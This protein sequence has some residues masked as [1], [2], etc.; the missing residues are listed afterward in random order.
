[1][2]VT[3]ILAGVVGAEHVVTDR[4]VLASYETDWTGRFSGR[5]LAVVRPR[6]TT[7]VAG[8]VRHC[9]DA[10]L[11]ICVQGGNT[12]L[13]GGS[14]PVDGAVLLSLA[15]LDV[16]E[17]V[18]TVAG[19]VTVGAG[20]PLARLQQHVRPLGFDVGVD[21]AARESCTVGGM[22]ATNAGGERVLRYGTMRAQVL[23]VEAV[24]ANATVISRLHGLPKDNTG[25]DVV[26]LMVGAEGTLGVLTRLRLRLVPLLAGRAVALVALDGTD[27][28]VSLVRRARD[29]LPSLEAAELCFANGIDLVRRHTGLPAPFADNHP[30]YLLLECAQH[31]DPSDDLL[32]LLENSAEVRDATLA[33]DARG[34]HALW[35][36]REAHTECINAEGVP[37]KLDVAVPLRSLADCVT[38]LPGV[39]AEASPGARP[40]LFG[41]VNEGN[42][43][44]NVLDAR[45]DAHAVTDAV[46]R[47]V[48]SFGGSISAEHGVGRAKQAWLSLSRSEEEIA[49]MRALK[50][51]LDPRGLLNPGVL[52]PPA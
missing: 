48:A 14:V 1:M 51:A 2:T 49:M 11:A 46:L 43:H 7:E 25:Y 6:D 28:A 9:A 50:A 12:G 36:Y 52:L 44:V 38:Q 10:G 20:V 37:V 15:R 27:A 23:G 31:D 13:V 18:D 34:R 19:Q 16:I 45:D 24:L 29:V 33:A 30:A 42:L 41:H 4:S 47:L 40:I 22:A 5:A 3:D 39:I 35:Q 21:F 26:S 17:A 32:A 8:V